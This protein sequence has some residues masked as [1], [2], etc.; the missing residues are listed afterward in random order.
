MK[1]GR[2]SGSGIQGREDKCRGIEILITEPFDSSKERQY[3]GFHRNPHIQSFEAFTI[4]KPEPF[5]KNLLFI[6][7]RIQKPRAEDKKGHAKTME[8][9]HDK[10]MMSILRKM[11]LLQQNNLRLVVYVALSYLCMR[12]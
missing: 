9:C 3:E 6:C 2:V 10:T 4:I 5:R 11:I 1:H 7:N 8:K 12:T